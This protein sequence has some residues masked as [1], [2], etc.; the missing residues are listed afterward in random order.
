MKVLN[1]IHYHEESGYY[2]FHNGEIR[3]DTLYPS[4]IVD[5]IQDTQ[6]EIK[7]TMER[8]QLL[9]EELQKD[10]NIQNRARS[11]REFLKNLVGKY[12]GEGGIRGDPVYATALKTLNVD[13]GMKRKMAEVEP[14]KKKKLTRKKRKE[15]VSSSKALDGSSIG[16]DVKDRV[17]LKNKGSAIMQT[18]ETVKDGQNLASGG[19][20]GGGCVDDD[21]GS[22]MKRDDD[23]TTSPK[24]ETQSIIPLEQKE[25]FV[26]VEQPQPQQ[27]QQQQQQPQQQQQQH[28]LQQQQDG[29]NRSLLQ[30]E[31]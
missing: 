9:K 28:P 1:V 26:M 14:V 13:L 8:I 27:Q 24:N 22:S 16:D 25:S 15:D 3:G 5:I 4:D 29:L 2:Y 18:N 23:V 7:E 12:D 17:V 30:T 20:D 10:V 21:D 6:E 11:A 19:G 31:K